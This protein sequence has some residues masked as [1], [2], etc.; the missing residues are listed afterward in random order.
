LAGDTQNPRWALSF[1]VSEKPAMGGDAEYLLKIFRR[2]GPGKPFVV[3]PLENQ[4][5]RAALLAD[6]RKLLSFKAWLLRPQTVIAIDQGVLDIPFHYLATQ[7]RSISPGGAARSENQSFSG[8]LDESE[9]QAA[10]DRANARKKVLQT[11]VTPAGFMKRL[12]DYSCSGCHQTR[13]IAGFHF[14]G[15]DRENAITANAV[16]I[17]GSAHFFADVPRHRA[18]IEEFARGVRVDFNRG[19]SCRPLDIY[20]AALA[21]TQLFDGWGAVCYAPP[22][23]AAQDASFA[24]W[25]CASGLTCRQLHASNGE[26]HLGVCVTDKSVTIGDPLEFGD[27]TTAAFGDEDYQRAVPAPS[28]GLPKAPAG[29]TDYVASHQEYDPATSSGGFPA[30]MLRIDGCA[31]LPAE[32]KCGR[33]AA[34]G[35]NR[36]IADG[37]PFPECLKLTKTAGLRACDRANPCRQD[38]ICTSPYKD[39]QGDITKGTCIPPYFVFRFRVDGQPSSFGDPNPL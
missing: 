9:I 24:S 32:A 3:S 14:P 33:V 25:T 17:P 4:I 10:L 35:F 38:Y 30:G 15:A 28:A 18:V 8:L 36:C 27:V 16:H 26:P 29:R 34:T 6:S 23:G 2:D 13:A 1:P 39:L 22:P 20:R 37:K 11:V 19:F 21:G 31:N 12:D 7:A 5:D